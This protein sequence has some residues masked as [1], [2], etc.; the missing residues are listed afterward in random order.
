MAVQTINVGYLANDGTGD[1]LR[2]AFIK[3][4]ENFGEMSMLVDNSI[5]TEAENVGT[6]LSVLRG[7]VGNKFEFKTLVDG[8]GIRLTEDGNSITVTG[9][10]GMEE[11]LVVTDNG[12][13]M[14]GAGK[15]LLPIQNG[16]NV[17]STVEIIP[18]QAPKLKLNVTGNGLVALDPMPK[19]SGDLQGNQNNIWDV[20]K[21]T[22][23]T[24]KGD[25]QGTVWGIDVR[26]LES[27]IQSY[28]FGALGDNTS[29]LLEFFFRTVDI[30]HGTFTAPE[31]MIMDLGFIRN[32]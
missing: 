31:A 15:P 29:S 10:P 30:D 18:G 11:L 26:S 14:L 17:E 3:V 6:G 13:V 16:R 32:I 5:S 20:D 19:L 2:E 21:V 22:A 9:D 23:R 1:D 27:L 4:N 24:F 7:K 28:D 8:Y 12:S 25:V